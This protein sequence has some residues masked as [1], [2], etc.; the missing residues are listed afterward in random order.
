MKE[1]SVLLE[2]IGEKV[3]RAH[4]LQWFPLVKEKRVSALKHDEY[5]NYYSCGS[6]EHVIT[7]SNTRLLRGL[8]WLSSR[9]DDDEMSRTLRDLATQMYKK[10][11]GVGMRNAK[12]G[13]AALYSLSVMPGTV[14]L[15]EIIVMRAATRYNPALVNINRVFDK[16]AEASG[17]TPDELA[18]LSI[19]GYG[20][21]GLGEFRQQVGEFEAVATLISVGKCELLWAKGDKTQKSVPATIKSEYADDVKSIKGIIKDVQIGCAAHSLRLEQMYLR[22]KSLDYET[23]QEQYVD[24]KLI[25]FL[26]RRLIWRIS[27]NGT[28][29]NVI[30][31]ESGYIDHSEAS[32]EIP[33]DAII[34]LWP[35]SMSAP[36][37]T[38]AWRNLLIDREITQPFKQAHREIYLLTD[39]ER[40]TRDY[41][42]RFANHI[43]K[44][45]QF[46]ALATQRGWR[47]Q[48]G[49]GWDGGSENSASK[50]LPAFNMDVSF[51]AR[52][53]NPMALATLVST[54][55]LPREKSF[56]Q[57]IDESAWKQ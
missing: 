30:H 42:L 52:V 43:L 16:L 27:S 20:L 9:F 26:A 37:E 12:L 7:E 18:E 23:W 10:V 1:V 54:N 19:P 39:A 2:G 49:G 8:I 47:Q 14:G 57:T 6:T 31:A 4:L 21:T 34:D 46:H 33:A 22:R 3:F 15:K 45:S 48:R 41:S 25:G 11:Y 32:I 13:N 28:S 53:R 50:H 51:E 29:V 35:P 5:E 38:L 40:A 17:K 56:F 36:E 24:H 44:H 55:V